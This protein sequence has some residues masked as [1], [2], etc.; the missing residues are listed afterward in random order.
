MITQHNKIQLKEIVHNNDTQLNDKNAVLSTK[1]PS[2][3][4]NVDASITFS[5]APLC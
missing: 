2:I 4:K 1:T 5:S 3:T